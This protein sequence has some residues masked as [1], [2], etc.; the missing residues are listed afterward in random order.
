MKALTPVLLLLMVACSSPPTG[1][2]DSENAIAV[3]A[4]EINQQANAEIT[5]QVQEIDTAANVEAA[6]VD[7]SGD[8]V[9]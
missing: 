7:A 1:D 9:E 3:R 5:K 4:E 8:N 2:A 6:D